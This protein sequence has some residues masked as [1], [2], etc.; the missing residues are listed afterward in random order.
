MKVVYERE[1][2]CFSLVC[3]FRKAIKNFEVK[4]NVQLFRVLRSRARFDNKCAG[5]IQYMFSY[6]NVISMSS[7]TILSILV[8]VCISILGFA[9]WR[10]LDHSCA[11]LRFPLEFCIGHCALAFVCLMQLLSNMLRR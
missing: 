10:H 8:K 2:F 6:V 7:I 11:L 1:V 9:N 4:V 5:I 3:T